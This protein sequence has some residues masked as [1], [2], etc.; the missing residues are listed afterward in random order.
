MQADP[1]D[2]IER[3]LIEGA[4]IAPTSFDFKRRRVELI[5]L[6]GV[7]C[8]EPFFFE[9]IARLKRLGRR[10]IEIEVNRFVRAVPPDRVGPD[11]FIFHTGRCGSTGGTSTPRRRSPSSA[12]GAW[13]AA[14][15][16]TRTA[17]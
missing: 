2:A 17:A 4:A 5:D 13:P 12:T 3:R 10:P 8:R 1:G 11:G 7:E 9:T 6:E 16:T 14:P 15:S